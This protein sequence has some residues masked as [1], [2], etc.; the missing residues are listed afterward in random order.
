M[1][2]YFRAYFVHSRAVFD[3]RHSKEWPLFLCGE[4]LGVWD[5]GDCFQAASTLSHVSGGWLTL[6]HAE[7][8]AEQMTAVNSPGSTFSTLFFFFSLE[9]PT[10]IPALLNVIKP[11]AVNGTFLKLLET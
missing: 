5:R 10:A 6:M 8:E 11:L 4:Q 1:I 7:P 3:Q 2:L 9:A